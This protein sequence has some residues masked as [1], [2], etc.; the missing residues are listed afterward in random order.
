MSKRI[1]AILID[2]EE[3]ARNILANLLDRF[4]PSIELLERFSNLPD[5]VEGARR[6]QPDVVFLDIEMPNYAGFEIV[7]FF[8]TIPFEIIFTTAYD[9]YAIKAFEVAALDYLLKPI[10]IDRLKQAVERL[11]VRIEKSATSAQQMELLSETLKTNQV[12]KIAV[13]EKGY[14]QLVKVEDVVAI[15]AQESYS[16]IHFSNRSNKVVSKNLKHFETL[17]DGHG[18]F[19]R[20]HKSWIV[21]STY[22]HNYSRSRLEINLATNV[23]AKLSKY[24]KAEFEAFLDRK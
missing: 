6:L 23:I 13:M 7:N 3:S 8:E 20:T 1:S 15:E 16:K 18:D 21:N 24:R 19:F 14:R 5:G 10:D 22:L 2:D 9:K 4:C 12:T 17:L 11:E